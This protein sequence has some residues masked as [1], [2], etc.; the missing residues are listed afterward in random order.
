MGVLRLPETLRR[1]RDSWTLPGS[2]CK[3]QHPTLKAPDWQEWG[4]WR[5]SF[6]LCTSQDGAAWL[7][8]RACSHRPGIFLWEQGQV[9]NMEVT[10]QPGRM[11]NCIRGHYIVSQATLFW[12]SF[13]FC[14]IALQ[15]YLLLEFSVLR[16]WEKIKL[17]TI[18]PFMITM[19][20]PYFW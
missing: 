13:R 5:P 15:S 20:I 11:R 9:L 10:H 1:A 4:S 2:K 17:T 19:T 16:N 18:I 3:F 7:C 12:V 14:T 8:P 6:C